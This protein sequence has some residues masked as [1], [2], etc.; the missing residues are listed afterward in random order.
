MKTCLTCRKQITNKRRRYCST[1]CFHRRRNVS[2]RFW[3]YVENSSG[4]DC[5]QWLG[6]FNRK[7]YGTFSIGNSS[8]LRNSSELA[9][10]VA[11]ELLKAPIPEGRH[12]LHHCDNTGCVNPGHLFLGDDRINAEDRNAKGRTA[13]GER[14]GM[15]KLTQNDVDWVHVYANQA[16]WTGMFIA[17]C[18]GISKSTVYSV[19][20]DEGW[21]YPR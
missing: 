21:R 19:L 10:R 9:H 8:G 18:L 14:N 15:H 11:W 17:E 6:C 1:A 16:G 7:G 12:V 5:W 13:K 3:S 4:A 20:N 2:D